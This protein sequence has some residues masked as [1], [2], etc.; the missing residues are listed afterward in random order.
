MDGLRKVPDNVPNAEMLAEHLGKPLT[1]VPDPFGDHPSFAT[2]NNAMLRRFLDRF[3]F[4]YEFVSSTDYYVGGRFDD[5][6]AQVLRHWDDILGVMLP[7]LREERRLTYSPILPISPTSGRVLQVPVTVIDADSR[8]HRLHR[9]RRH[10]HRAVR[11]RR[12]V[13]AAVEGRLGDA[14]GRARRRL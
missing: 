2:H 13:E 9:R 14:L 10:P 7:T 11:A 5:A 1:K 4:D 8:H 6:I 12:P 3:G